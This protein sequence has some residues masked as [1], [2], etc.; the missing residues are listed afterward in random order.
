MLCDRRF[1]P[2]VVRVVGWLDVIVGVQFDV[3]VGV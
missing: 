3:S 1:V 2:I